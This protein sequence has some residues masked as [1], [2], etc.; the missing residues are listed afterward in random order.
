MSLALDL[1]TAVRPTQALRRCIQSMGCI[2]SR[3]APN[4]T[5][6]YNSD[7]ALQPPIC[8]TTLFSTPKCRSS[9]SALP[10]PPASSP[11]LTGRRLLPLLTFAPTNHRGQEEKEKKNKHP[12]TISTAPGNL[13][14]PIAEH[15]QIHRILR[16][17]PTLPSL[18]SLEIPFALAKPAKGKSKAVAVA[19]DSTRTFTAHPRSHRITTRRSSHNESSRFD[20]KLSSDIF[21]AAIASSRLSILCADDDDD[22]ECKTTDINAPLRRHSG[23]RS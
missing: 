8:I 3:A 19:A 4:Q 6:H 9:L 7:S 16:Y 13:N 10:R 15:H 12:P 20:S 21:L 18:A 1:K 17:R 22:H 2:K 14:L 23:T 5:L 11:V